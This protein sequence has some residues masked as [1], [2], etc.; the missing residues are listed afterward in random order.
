VS[1]LTSL[2]AGSGKLDNA[3]P[4]AMLN[5]SISKTSGIMCAVGTYSMAGGQR[6]FVD[7]IRGWQLTAADNRRLFDDS[8]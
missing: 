3:S 4:S 5:L 2:P 6:S 8:S 7:I 1:G